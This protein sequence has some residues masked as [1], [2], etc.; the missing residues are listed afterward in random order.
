[1]V[2]IYNSI[3]HNE[4]VSPERHNVPAHISLP[5]TLVESV[6]YSKCC[7]AKL[8]LVT[9]PNEELGQIGQDH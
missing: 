9:T 8:I 4:D 1:M 2:Y 5:K 6:A 7:P 3:Q